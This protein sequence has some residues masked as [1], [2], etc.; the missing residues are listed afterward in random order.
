MAI[1][2]TI[3]R[4]REKAG[5]TQEGMAE[6]LGTTRSNYAY[7]EGRGE[8]LTLEQLQSIAKA[9][10]VSLGEI[11]GMETKTAK[12]NAEKLIIKEGQ[13]NLVS[14]GLETAHKLIKHLYDD[15]RKFIEVVETAITYEI[16]LSA[17]RLGII[18]KKDCEGWFVFDE[19]VTTGYFKEIEVDYYSLDNKGIN[20]SEAL[21][22]K[23]MTEKQ[24]IYAL[25]DIPY[26]IF[27]CLHQLFDLNVL[28]DEVLKRAIHKYY[29]GMP[30]YLG[31]E[32][33]GSQERVHYGR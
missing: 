18:E 28:S 33:V 1:T 21:P 6:L 29:N 19:E 11:L 2:D 14:E 15:R 5:L 23:V 22:S 20:S 26:W 9:L 24:I 25:K 16:V 10:K 13:Y 4:L 30:M 27:D 7:L 8:K 31:N 32:I 3:R 12:E 17:I